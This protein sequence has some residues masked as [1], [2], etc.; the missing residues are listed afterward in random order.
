MLNWK[1]MSIGKKITFG[2][3]GAVICIGLIACYNYL[4][5][6]HIADSYK[7][8]DI[9]MHDHAFLLEK[10][11]DHLKWVSKLNDLFLNNKVTTLEIETD[12][13]KCSLGKWLYGDK[14]QAIADRNKH[15]AELISA[16]KEPHKRLH[17]SAIAIGKLYTASGV[18][19]DGLL[20]ERWI[21]HLTWIKNL[22][23]SLL[24]G[25]V[26]TGTLDPQLCA[27]G[28][29]YSSYKAS[30]PQLAA[31]LNKW[32]AP[33]DRLHNSAQK[34]V[35][36]QKNHNFKLA[37]KIYQE[38]TLPA[39]TQLSSR[40]EETKTWVNSN[41]KR[42]EAAVK[43]LYTDTAT[44]LHDVQT[45]IAKLRDEID[46][47]ALAAGERMDD[48]I[49][50]TIFMVS[51]VSFI[52]IA[53]GI[54]SA[55][56]II[57]AVTK[58]LNRSIKGL[59]NGSE[60]VHNA[61]MHIAA[62][63]QELAEA[64][65]EQSATIE[66]ISA[67]MEELTS[68]TRQ[69]AKNASA[70][71]GYMKE[72]SQTVEQATESM[73]ELTASMEAISS[74]SEKTSKIIKTIDEISFQTNLLALN[75]AVEAARA[76]DAGS[77]FAVVA[78]EVRSLAM[79]A[80]DSAKDTASLIEETVNKVKI[81]A[82]ILDKTN[83][84]FV[85]VANSTE[86]VGGLL[87]EITAASNEQY[88]GIEQINKAVSEMDAVVQRVAANSEESASAAEQLSS[89]SSQTQDFVMEMIS[90]V[91]GSNRKEV[92]HRHAPITAAPPR[93]KPKAAML[94]KTEKPNGH[95]RQAADCQDVTPLRNEQG[96]DGHD[97]FK[98]F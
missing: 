26:F 90:L 5:L 41:V 47:D 17:Q 54:M 70:A 97:D 74:S 15:Y 93:H 62:S 91:Q 42:Q 66:E 33:H 9:R 18:D 8:V 69:N 39:L 49:N 67:S 86:K 43:I 35:A 28:K 82:E 37:N 87:S 45:I 55:F 96:V 92:K 20:A 85:E 95:E 61:S 46:K 98:D 53:M 38:E 31:L 4:H 29:W 22:S 32:K 25:T 13:H 83:T 40:Y 24:T 51:T 34:I 14:V 81:G 73:K 48:S 79:R 10:E 6:E 11:I 3:G 72:T 75:A 64:A 21:D 59:Q 80:A 23:N 7:Q 89:Q 57:R 2:F 78:E 58:P 12:D 76:G 44:A 1:G 60:Q 88:H 50:S 56:I 52:A 77:G 16:I 19:L 65:S 84:A 36:A 63:G 68:M 71:D 30:D 94:P 27:F